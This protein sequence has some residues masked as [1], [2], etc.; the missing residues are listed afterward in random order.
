MESIWAAAFRHICKCKST[1]RCLLYNQTYITHMCTDIH[2]PLSSLERQRQG[3]QGPYCHRKRDKS[4]YLGRFPEAVWGHSYLRILRSNRRT[5]R[6]F[7]LRLQSWS[8]WQGEFLPQGT[9]ED[10][11][12]WFS[13]ASAALLEDGKDVQAEAVCQRLLCFSHWND[14]AW[15]KWQW[16]VFLFPAGMPVCPHKVRHREGRAGQ[17]LQRILYQSP[18]RWAHLLGKKRLPP[19]IIAPVTFPTPSA[20]SQARPV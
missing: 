15:K 8:N 10:H 2:I 18:H 12:R 1:V 5:D 9:W 14:S 3:S 4:W 7:Q 16:H 13:W 19:G 17:K 20:L 11:L 6:L